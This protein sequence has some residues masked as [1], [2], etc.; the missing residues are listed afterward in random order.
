MSGRPTKQG[1]KKRIRAR[2]ALTL[3]DETVGGLTQL[4]GPGGSMSAVVEDL[5]RERIAR[6]DS[7]K[8]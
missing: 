2:V 1:K 7:G 8:R 5:V 4:A 3:S 6:E